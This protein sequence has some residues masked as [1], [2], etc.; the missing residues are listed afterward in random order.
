MFT[1]KFERR[2]YIAA[3]VVVSSLTIGVSFGTYALWPANLE[4]GYQPAQPI[5]FSHAIMA[6]QFKIECIYCHSRAEQSAHATIPPT[7]TCMKCHTEIQT[8]DARGA[9]KANIQKLLKYW[10]EKT[11]IPWEKVYDLADFVYFDHSRHLT[12]AAKLDCVDCHGKVETMDRVERVYS[13]KM[14][15]GLDCHMEPPPAGSPP[16]QKTRAP[17]HCSTCHR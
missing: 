12:A 8:K 15:W 9:V 2:I 11:P 6:G 4:I 16:W 1:R 13:L 5:E 17:I 10:E 14:R 7:S 3:A